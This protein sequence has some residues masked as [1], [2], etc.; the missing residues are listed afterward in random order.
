MVPSDQEQKKISMES[1]VTLEQVYGVSDDVVVREIEDELII[2]PI[3]TGIGDMEAEL[4]T[5]NETGKAI[6]LKIDGEK[7]LS[8]IAQDLSETYD[9][10]IEQI[11]QDVLGIVGELFKRRMLI[12]QPEH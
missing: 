8:Q 7:T 2:V 11:E 1:G 10:P 9:A 5:M 6:L 12:K 4:Y 3:A